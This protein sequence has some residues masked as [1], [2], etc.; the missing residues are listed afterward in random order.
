MFSEPDSFP[1]KRSY[2]LIICFI[3]KYKGAGI[4]QSEQKLRYGLDKGIGV[5]FS[6]GTRNVPFRSIQTGSE[7]HPAFYPTSIGSAFLGG[8]VAGALC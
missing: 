4:A 8:K 2:M 5:R 7:A 3:F 1:D 6:V